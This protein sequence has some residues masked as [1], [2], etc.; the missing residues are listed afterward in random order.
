MSIKSILAHYSPED[1]VMVLTGIDGTWTH[2]VSGGA[3]GQFLTAERLIPHA[4]NYTGAQGDSVR[5]IRDVRHYTLTVSLHLAAETNDVFSQII[6]NDAATRDGSKL[7]SLMIKDT[8]GRTVLS[9]P[10][11]FIGTTPTLGYSPDVETRDWELFIYN[12]QEH[13]GGNGF[14]LPDTSATLTE[15][16]YEADE[17]WNIQGMAP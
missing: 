1:I 17:H 3:D 9:S 4:T 6:A 15:L 14:L 7:F 2:Q 12:V 11:G 13:I 16:G 8:I 10:I 5:V